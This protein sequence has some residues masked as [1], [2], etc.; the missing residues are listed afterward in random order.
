M[1][2]QE[3]HLDNFKGDFLNI[4]ILHLQITDF[5]IVEI[6]QILSYPNKASLFSFQMSALIQLSFL[7]LNNSFYFQ[8]L[9]VCV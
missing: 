1:P 3:L 5:Q 7:L 8:K 6:G 2:C 4:L 9:Y